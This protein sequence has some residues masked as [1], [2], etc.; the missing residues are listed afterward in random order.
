MTYLDPKDAVFGSAATC[1]VTMKNQKGEDER[2]QMFTITDFEAKFA[3]NIKEV[4]I[5]GKT[6]SGHKAAGGKGTFSG[7]MYYNTSIFRK[8]AIDYIK[9]DV[10]QPF[11]WKR[12]QP[13]QRVFAS[14]PIYRRTGNGRDCR[15]THSR[16]RGGRYRK[17]AG[18][19]L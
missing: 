18:T 2:Y 17:P 4:K 11:Q 7:K 9:T 16:R 14:D 19:I 15:R 13:I 6:T 10:M 12:R 3:P 1:Y 5:L 8:W